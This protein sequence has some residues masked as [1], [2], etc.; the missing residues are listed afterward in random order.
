M[1][2]GLP[3]MAQGSGLNGRWKADMASMKYDGATV[4]VTGDDKAFTVSGTGP[5]MKVVCDGKP[6]D[7]RDG[8]KETCT[9]AGMVYTMVSRKGGKVV[10]RG[11]ATV[12]G[13]TE[14][15][16][17]TIYPSDGSAPFSVTSTMKRVSGGP[18]MVGVWKEVGF[19]SAS[20]TG[21]LS[22]AVKGDMIAFK[23]TDDPKPVN[24]KLGGPDQKFLDGMM[25]I[26]LA[27][28]HT[29]KVTYKGDDGKVRRENTFALSGDGKTITETD[30][31]PAP[32]ASKMVLTLHKQ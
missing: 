19:K 25:S 24:A 12:A 4:T 29:L 7:G 10:S 1:G 27:D 17:F 14:T 30:I 6:F 21:I 5:D 11:T 26:R 13:D 16:R 32:G 8:E 22:I 3:A 20:E 2:V 9:K 28:D 15:R 31:T 23:E 18:G